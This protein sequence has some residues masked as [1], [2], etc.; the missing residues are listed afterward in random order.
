MSTGEEFAFDKSEDPLLFFNDI[1]KV[2]KS[3]EEAKHLQQ[4]YEKYLK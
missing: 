3:L 1:K 4:Y 2:K